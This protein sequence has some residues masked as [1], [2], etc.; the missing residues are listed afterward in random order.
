MIWCQWVGQRAQKVELGY[1][2]TSHT[3]DE[4]THVLSD[5][6]SA[7]LKDRLYIIS[8]STGCLC[9]DNFRGRSVGLCHFVSFLHR[10]CLKGSLKRHGL[11]LCALSSSYL[12]DVEG[13][14]HSS[15]FA[16]ASEMSYQLVP[17]WVVALEEGLRSVLLLSVASREFMI[18]SKLVQE[19]SS[20]IEMMLH[21]AVQAPAPSLHLEAQRGRAD[22]H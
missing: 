17:E 2:S 5:S 8:T 9:A 11:D 13:S 22:S 7:R 3:P 21:Q 12:D 18:N 19:R 16:N 20:G 4:G 15:F 1:V 10:L 6:W 14:C